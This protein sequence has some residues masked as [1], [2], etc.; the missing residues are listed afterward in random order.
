LTLIFD[1]DLNIICWTLSSVNPLVDDDNSTSSN[2]ILM[3][4]SD[5]MRMKFQTSCCMFQQV[6]IILYYIPI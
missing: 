1:Y 2:P 6:T 5:Y 4:I 3:V